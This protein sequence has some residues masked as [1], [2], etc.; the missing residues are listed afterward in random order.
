MR[1]TKLAG[2]VSGSL[3]G[4]IVLAAG[5]VW[6]GG[7]K[8]A[9]WA[10]E[11]PLS[12]MLGRQIEVGNLAIDW[13]APSRIVLEDVHIANA[14]WG[15]DKEMF[16]ARRLEIA[17]FA[18]NLVWGPLRVPLVG[19]D[20]A[21]LLL[22]TS[23][24][25]DRN[26]DFGLKSA[27]PQKRTQ[28]PDLEKFV[29]H[30]S[31]FRYRNG[32][33]KAESDLGVTQL[34]ITAP[35]PESP[36]RI[37]A[38]GRFQDRPL[39][40]AATVGPLSALRDTTQPYPVKL[41]GMLE[42]IHVVADGTMKE[43]LDFAGVDLRLSLD[44]SDLDKLASMLGVPFPEVPP[45]RGTAKLVGGNGA[46]ELQALTF[47]LGKSNLEGGIAIDTNAKVPQLQAN[48]TS[49]AIDLADFKGVYG[50]KPGHSA[51]PPDPSGRVLP[52][53]PIDVHK[54]PGINAE[55]SFDGARIT[56]AG[57]LPIDRVSLG[58]Q[59]RDGTLTVKPLRF[60]VAK[61][62]V[63]LNMS[64]TPFTKDGPPRL[65]ADVDVRHVDLHGLLGG[66]GMPDIV[67]QVA[68]NAGGFVKIDTRGVSTREFLAHMN[69]DAGL[70]IENGQLSQLL[71]QLAPI[72][73]LGAL[74][75]YARGDKPVPINCF[76]SRFDI[77]NGVATIATLLV[78]TPED[79]IV[80]KGGINFADETLDLSLTPNNKHFTL[81]S[82]R[83]PVTVDG[84]FHK[85]DYHLKAAGLITRLG[86]AAGLGVLFPPAALLPLIDTGLGENNACSKAYAAQNPPGSPVPAS[87]NGMPQ[88]K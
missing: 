58:L 41:D 29:A 25:G 69:G 64:F 33:T 5:A 10:I 30:D 47:A 8:A 6:F 77:K 54:F 60:H 49:S 22:E 43:P 75:V 66:P 82:L 20:G 2:W 17:L 68:G 36:V 7:P 74:G 67:R 13:G 39:R 59:L 46:F 56:A 37:A 14:S 16:S 44:G 62:D 31:A 1:W 23:D 79:D 35:D 48:L 84:T 81:V 83:T 4:L 52:D 42:K 11:H 21:K 50:G 61:G 12:R 65:K 15:S 71:E 18:R 24:Q 26:W 76:V 3:L 34:E 55:I 38:E 40:L 28:F 87:G 85:P 51:T 53:T 45:F 63:D 70:F 86:A 78:D 32:E 19:L 73:V 27:A 72:D 57:G 9:I 80:G 88:S